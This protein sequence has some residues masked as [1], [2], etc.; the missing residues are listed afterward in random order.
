MHKLLGVK[1]SSNPT[2]AGFPPH[3]AA[4]VTAS[5]LMALGTLDAEGRPWTT[6][7][8]GEPG[9]AHPLEPGILA[10]RSLADARHDPVLRALFAEDEDEER[11]VSGLSID[12]ATRDRV[13]LAGRLVAGRVV[14]AAG[15]GGGGGV[16]RV[17]L[18]MLVQESLGN[19]PKYLNKRTIRAHVPAP[20]LVSDA[21]PLPREALDLLER[22]DLFFLSSTDGETMD[23][24]HRGGPPGFVRVVSNDARGGVRLVYPEYSGNRLYQT[25]GNLHVRP[26]AGIC[27][28]DLAT[29]AVLYLTGETRV[30]AGAD[31]ARVLPRAR[32]AVEVAV[33][34]A[35]LVR[36]G[37][38]FRGG[39][40][41]DYS[42]YNPRVWMPGG[43]GP[44]PEAASA[45]ATLTGREVLSPSIARFT[46]SLEPVARWRAGQHVTLD[47]AGELDAGWSHMRDD[48]PG[49]LNDDFVRTFTVSN[50]PPREGGGW[51]EEMQITVRR[52]GPATGLLWRWNLRVPLEL[53][54]L[55][56]GGEGGF[57]AAEDGVA[58]EGGAELVFVAAG[59]GIT[60]LL[61]QAPG[62]LAGG[63]G[64]VLLWSLRAEDVPFAVDA[65]EK[66]EGLAARTRL[67][68]TGGGEDDSS[69]GGIETLGSEVAR[70]RIGRED[71]LQEGSRK[72]RRYH[73]CTGTE[74]LKAL[75]V[76][77]D[78]EDVV[79]ESFEY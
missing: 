44:G 74:M 34:A 75:L 49:S 69:T 57:G 22:A 21:L 28:P 62:L 2:W 33:E 7:W 40:G 66:I 70:G 15:G 73:L 16:A 6:V 41:V 18:A 27:V 37:L 29:G 24:N 23:T 61:A 10:A 31:A 56:F 38:P 5:P 25:L 11:L 3:L 67:F 32:L 54:L 45:T 4:R 20:E 35:R 8:G 71:V 55:G 36:D 42:P 9:F 17:Q 48:D 53:P 64:F 51:A 76:W 79:Y 68:V 58:R 78:G 19:C 39:E 1:Q 65:F 46:F 12:L 14:D 43:S 77:L 26:A 47:F 50:A 63:M 13:K 72:R 52:H 60:P 59:V 30:L